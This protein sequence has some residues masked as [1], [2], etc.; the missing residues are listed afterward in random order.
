MKIWKSLFFLMFVVSLASCRIVQE[1]SV[2][3]VILSSSGTMDCLLGPC[4]VP[5]TGGFTQTFTARPDA[6]YDFVAWKRICSTE[7]TEVCFLEL[8][9]SLTDMDADVPIVA[10]FAPTPT[11]NLTTERVVMGTNF[12]FIV[13]ELFGDLSPI[14]VQNFLRYVDAGF[15]DGTIFHRVFRGSIDGIQGGGFGWRPTE[16]EYPIEG[17]Y[18]LEPGAPI[19]NESFNRLSNTLGTIAMARTS[20]P[21]SA[22]S[23]FFFNFGDNSVLDYVSDSQDGYAVFGRVVTGIEVI[24]ALYNLELFTN[25]AAPFGELPV[26]PVIITGITRHKMPP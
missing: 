19:Q 8:P 3:G 17:I 12:G 24:E 16:G 1:P 11:D 4:V 2:G 14:T 9:A 20:A 26:E 6:G 25:F 7:P 18:T 10:L 22:T 5:V 21:D 23:Q 13:I 15:Y